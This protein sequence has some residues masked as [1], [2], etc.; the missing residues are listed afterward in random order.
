M[1]AAHCD[2]G[3]VL[4]NGSVRIRTLLYRIE[5]NDGCAEKPRA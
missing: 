4:V 2:G 5:P 1:P 3:S